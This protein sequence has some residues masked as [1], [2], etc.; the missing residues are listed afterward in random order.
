MAPE[1]KSKLKRL[2]K[3]NGRSEADIIREAINALPER[4]DPI[5]A[6]LVSQG[7]IDLP[8]ATMTSAEAEVTYD[9]YL[10]ELGDRQLDLTKALIEERQGQEKLA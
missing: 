6:A 10:K 4:A 7:L 3:A 9:R 2:A 1:H 8:G 5:L